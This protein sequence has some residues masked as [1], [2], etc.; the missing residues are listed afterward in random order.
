MNL[1]CQELWCSTKGTRPL[2]VAHA[3]F[4]ESEIRNFYI[5]I[6]I[7]KQIV[8]FQV[9]VHDFVFMQELKSKDHTTRIKPVCAI[10]GG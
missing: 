2:S 7:K 1:W 8:E 4:A 9:P 3:F 5:S 6:H 10:M